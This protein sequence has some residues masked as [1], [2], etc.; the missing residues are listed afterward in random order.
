MLIKGEGKCVFRGIPAEARL[1]LTAGWS[2]PVGEACVCQA[3]RGK[4]PVRE[5]RV[6]PTA[7]PGPGLG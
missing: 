7:T 5:S 1:K 2:C 6:S 3:V 4:L